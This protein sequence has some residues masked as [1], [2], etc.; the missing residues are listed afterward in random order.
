M[1]L[2]DLCACGPTSHGVFCADEVPEAKSCCASEDAPVV[3]EEHGCDCP[4]L[5]LDSS[6]KV[7]PSPGLEPA[8]LGPLALAGK[9]PLA[10]RI[11]P[12][13]SGIPP[14]PKPPPP[15]RLHLLLGVILS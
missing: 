3:A 6:L 14:Q 9:R 5:E 15:L 12:A 10:Q 2:I 7:Q 13:V 11:G 8:G 1:G 4:V